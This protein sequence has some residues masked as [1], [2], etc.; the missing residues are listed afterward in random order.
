VVRFDTTAKKVA[1]NFPAVQK[2][3]FQRI[4]N[5]VEEKSYYVL[6]NISSFQSRIRHP[7]VDEV[8]SAL[9]AIITQKN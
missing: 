6:S 8:Y 7:A 3:F 5:E 4:E 1:L 2:R 9:G